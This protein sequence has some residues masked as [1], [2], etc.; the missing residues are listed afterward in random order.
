MFPEQFNGLT[1]EH[2]NKA[3]LLSRL[4]LELVAELL[5]EFA[6]ESSAPTQVRIVCDKHG[7]RSRYGALLQ[8]QFDDSFIEV[9]REDATESRYAWGPAEARIEVRFR[10][11]GEDYLP[12]ALASMASKYLREAAMLA[13]NRFWCARVKEL[14]PTAGYPGDARRFKQQIEPLQRELGLADNLV[15]RTR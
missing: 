1:E 15:W 14:R 7:G 4:T 12:V 6:S 13:F 2:G 5:A 9:R 10:M 11:Q 3:E 8:R